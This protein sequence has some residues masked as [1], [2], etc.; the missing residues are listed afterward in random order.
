MKSFSPY[1]FKLFVSP[2]QIVTDSC[3]FVFYL[4]EGLFDDDQTDLQS[5]FGVGGIHGLPYVPWDGSGSEPPKGSWGGYCTHGSV[6][7]PTWHRPYVALYEVCRTSFF[8]LPVFVI[9]ETINLLAS[10][11]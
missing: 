7:F 11:A 9:D 4:P 8:I 6:L 2:Q 5:F 3:W 10:F 1:I